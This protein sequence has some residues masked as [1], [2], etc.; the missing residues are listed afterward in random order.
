[1]LLVIEMQ[2]KLAQV[3]RKNLKER[4]A[5]EL[6]DLN[7]IKGVN[8]YPGNLTWSHKY[9]TSLTIFVAWLPSPRDESFTF[10]VG[11]S[12]KN[13]FPEGHFPSISPS[14]SELEEFRVRIG[15]LFSDNDFWWDLDPFELEVADPMRYLQATPLET[16]LARVDSNLDD[17]ISKILQFGI[18]L[19]DKIK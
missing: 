4:V 3:I 5:K 17:A 18:P 12:R 15:L 7:L 13:R 9:H 6:P 8:P 1:M 14:N 11:W 16:L 19:L 10:E 2:R